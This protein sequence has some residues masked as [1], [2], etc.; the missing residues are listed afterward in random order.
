M[1]EERRHVLIGHL[2]GVDGDVDERIDLAQVA[3]QRLSF[4]LAE[5]LEEIL[6]AIE[7][8]HVYAVEVNQ[9]QVADADAGERH[10][11]R[12]AEAAATADGHACGIQFILGGRGMAVE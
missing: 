9:M 1:F 5:I 11:D 12:R 7:V 6:L 2:D 3:A 8:R 4:V 10:G